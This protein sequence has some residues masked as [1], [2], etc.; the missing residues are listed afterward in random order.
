MYAPEVLHYIGY[1]GRSYSYNDT[2][3]YDKATLDNI[4]QIYDALSCLAPNCKEGYKHWL[5]VPRG[6]L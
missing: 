3:I 1:L 6:S 4:D 5:R 2:P